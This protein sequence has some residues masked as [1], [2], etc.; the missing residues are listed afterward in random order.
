VISKY[1]ALKWE[2]YGIVLTVYPAEG[3]GPRVRAHE[4]LT[5]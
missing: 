3:W 5:C 1:A 2:Y 4:F